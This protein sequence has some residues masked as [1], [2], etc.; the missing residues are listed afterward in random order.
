MKS[1]S[2]IG[3][4]NQPL[5]LISI[6]N[7]SCVLDETSP[8]ISPEIRCLVDVGGQVAGVAPKSQTTH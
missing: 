1:V 6:D 8:L 5:I 7:Q 2:E 4:L 3:S